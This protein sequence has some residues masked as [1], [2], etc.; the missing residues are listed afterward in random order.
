[1]EL[2][3]LEPVALAARLSERALLVVQGSEDE[4]VPPE[5]GVA[6]AEAAG[7]SAELR[8]VLGAGHWLRAD[9]R[10]TATLIGWLERQA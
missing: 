3:D 4:A 2:G 1:R 7:T 9:P 10:A 6:L 8:M 5:A